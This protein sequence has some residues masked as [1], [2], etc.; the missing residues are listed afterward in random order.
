MDP[1]GLD[2]S[3]DKAVGGRTDPDVAAVILD[4]TG[5]AGKSG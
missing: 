2:E 4:S 5:K 1:A 3:T